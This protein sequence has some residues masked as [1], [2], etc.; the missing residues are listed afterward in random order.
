MSSGNDVLDRRPVQM[1]STNWQ[2]DEP[3]SGQRADEVSEYA[4]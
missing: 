2:T 3:H 4:E 1:Q